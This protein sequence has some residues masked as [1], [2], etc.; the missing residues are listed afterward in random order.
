MF[1]YKAV[2]L[3]CCLICSANFLSGMKENKD[4]SGL[5]RLLQ[6][7]QLFSVITHG[8][9]QEYQHVVIEV[10]PEP[11]ESASVQQPATTVPDSPALSPLA[12]V[13][14]L[15]FAALEKLKL[16]LNGSSV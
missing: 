7:E 15:F 16:Q 3:L 9:P 12:I 4:L 11:T 1:S 5:T 8:Q 10:R 2:I 14:A 13:G 6:Q